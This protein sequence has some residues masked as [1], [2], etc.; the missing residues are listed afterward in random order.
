MSAALP[1]IDHVQI[2]MPAGGEAAARHFFGELIGLPELPKPAELAARG[3]CWFQLAGA[4]LHV[5]VEADF[6][7]ARKA[8]V[9][10]RVANLD[11]LRA[12]L[13]QAG[14][15]VQDEKPALGHA[16]FFSADPFGNRIEFT[17]A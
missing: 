17:A 13:A 1:A 11:R 5:G 15:S 7:P 2:A 6:R 8:H 14:F 3:G 9:A 4:Q 12:A 16:R 10:L